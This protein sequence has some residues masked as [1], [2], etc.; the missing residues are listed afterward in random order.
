MPYHTI[1][2]YTRAA[3]A[4]RALLTQSTPFIPISK[5]TSTHAISIAPAGI[6]PDYTIVYRIHILI[7]ILI[8]IHNQ[9]LVVS[10]YTEYRPPFFFLLLIATLHATQDNLPAAPARPK[11]SQEKQN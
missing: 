10:G 3:R 11:Q 5:V 7:L 2:Y 4:A 9:P 8:L 1:P 6:L